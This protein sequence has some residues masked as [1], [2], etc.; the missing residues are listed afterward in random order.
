MID[1]IERAR[2]PAA[3]VP[4]D[5]ER[6]WELAGS[7]DRIGVALEDVGLGLRTIDDGGWQGRA[8]EAFHAY[9][10]E[11]PKR[12]L[13]AADA[14]LSTAVALDT[15]AGALSWAQRQAGEAI[16]L[17]HE[18]RWTGDRAVDV[19]PAQP[20]RQQIEQFGVLGALPDPPE[21]D[22]RSR[23][24]RRAAAVDTL[25]RARRQLE[26]IGREAADTVHAAG[27]L[28]PRG[29]PRRW[30][31]IARTTPRPVLVQTEP[32]V[33]SAAALQHPDASL[34]RHLDHDALRD[35]PAAWDAG[36][37]GLRR[38]LR[39]LGLDQ[40]SP[41]LRQHIFEGHYSVRKNRNLGYHHRE[42]G[43]DRGP[44]RVVRVIGRPDQ[45]GVYRAEVTG[46]RTG[47]RGPVKR[48]TFFPDA[49]TRAEVLRAIRHAFV[50]RTEFS[51]VRQRWRG[52]YAGVV[53]EG[54]V[55]RQLDA[56]PAEA[57]TARLYHV[58]TAYP[59]YRG[60][61]ARGQGD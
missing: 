24:D 55:E 57:L 1:E 25:H 30:D 40:L 10:D 4:G 19:P 47:P 51:A 48:S 7:L 15:Y 59:I 35:N 14:F 8:A 22:G 38:R 6:I 17:L 37:E 12:F 32:V 33:L 60:R 28:A 23:A 54:V 45:N 52:R 49:W 5:P 58:V 41:R 34:K 43:V 31:T 61:Q 29:R 21:R 50:H 13:T 44:L 18:R 9:F 16:A 42:G 2:D 11:T 26:R 53:I 39:R 36:I 20:M 46:P 3:L 27:V 56:Q